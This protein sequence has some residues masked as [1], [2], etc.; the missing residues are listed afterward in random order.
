MAGLGVVSKCILV[1]LGAWLLARLSLAIQAPGTE[2]APVWMPNAFLLGMLVRQSRALRVPLLLSG[3]V[4]ILLAEPYAPWVDMGLAAINVFEVAVAL[5]A[6]RLL[7]VGYGTAEDEHDFLRG[8]VGTIV[9]APGI[10]AL[11]AAG[12]L[13]AASGVDAGAAF[14]AWWKSGSVGML[15]LLPVMWSITLPGVLGLLRGRRAGEFAAWL[16]LVVASTVALTLMVQHPFV[17]MALPLLVAAYRINAFRTSVLGLVAAATCMATVTAVQAGLL[18]AMAGETGAYSIRDLGDV[19]LYCGLSAIGPILIAVVLQRR[20]MLGKSV[21]SAQQLLSMV[22]DAVPALIGYVDAGRRYRFVNSRYQEWLGKS[23]ADMLG[24]TAADVFGADTS[25]EFAPYVRAAL[26][27]REVRFAYRMRGVREVE[28][29]YTPH[30]VA[31]VVQGYTAIALDITER[32]R[33]ERALYEERGRSETTLQSIADAVLACDADLRVTSLNQVAAVLSGWSQ[34][35]AVG[36]P[37]DEVF[38]L[39]DRT[40]RAPIA[41][42]LRMVMAEDRESGVRSDALLQRR[43][44]VLVEI[45]ITAA[46]IHDGEG[47]VS[48]AVLIARDVGEARS[49]ASRLAHLAHHDYLTDLPNR[50]LLEDRISQALSAIARGR[51]GALLFVDL[52]LFK[53]VNDSLGHQ[54]GDEVLRIVAQRLTDTVRDDDTVSRQ[55]GDE[56]VVLLNRLAD[57]SDAARVAAKLIEVVEAPIRVEGQRVHLSASIGI[58]LFPQDARDV[59]TLLKQGDTALY[60]AKAGGRGRYSYFTESMS[61]RAGERMRLEAALRDALANDQLMLYYQPK[62]ALSDHCICGFEALVRWRMDDGRIVPPGDFIPIAEQ[63]G[64]ITVL[65]EWVMRQACR[66][67]ADWRARGL[68]PVPV[69]V[70]VSLARL[71]PQRLVDHVSTVLSDHGLDASLLEI[72]FT[73]S[74]MFQQRESTSA[75]LEQLKLLGVRITIDDFGTGYSS[76]GYLARYGFDVLKIDRS[77][78]NDLGGDARQAAI[79]E[80][81]LR[82]GQTLGYAVVAEG[83]ETRRQASV[84]REMGCRQV[85]GYLYSPPVDLARAEAML[86]AGAVQPASAA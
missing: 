39:V 55:G 34:D 27:G 49:M 66:H 17:L 58:A 86:R 73:E 57:A 56:F 48:G 30:V 11:A 43:D 72:E 7:R 5:F 36:R 41:S 18:P 28:V 84:L 79:V 33:A 83:V 47:R 76:L 13:H 46:P 61:Q 26:G 75:L 52:D 78:V 24:R 25:H 71:E 10:A 31:G 85:Q 14:L 59:A 64:L 8:A 21:R 16:L 2:L 70:N 1:A 35:D 62:V 15:L 65:D 82:I 3:A 77:F 38:P 29:V 23:P 60:H 63:S 32:V 51:A 54:A 50:L 45:E 44:G 40:S 74:Q 4:G 20:A 42:Q 37:V 12:F 6:L 19:G 9:L 67:V 69:A 81:V 68:D 53:H 80:A 22:T